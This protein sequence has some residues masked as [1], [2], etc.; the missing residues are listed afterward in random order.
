MENNEGAAE[1]GG[2]KPIGRVSSVNED[3]TVIIELDMTSPTAL[4]LIG[5][6][7]SGGREGANEFVR[8]ARTAF[9]N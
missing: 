6:Y 9:E 2:Q 5:S 1:Q 8:S 4:E 7:I 3:G